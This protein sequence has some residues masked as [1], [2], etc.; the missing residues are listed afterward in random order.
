MFGYD[1]TIQSIVPGYKFDA[2][3]RKHDKERYDDRLTIR[4]N[5]IDAF[6][7]L[8]GFVEKH[9]NDPFYIEGT[10]SISL[11]SLIFRE[12][13]ANIIAHR[14]YTSAA[15]ATMVIYADRV[16]FRNPN[17]P[18][19]H[20]RIDPNNFTPYPKNPTIC[21]FMIQLGRYEEL[22]SGV[23]KVN[24][25]LPHYAPGAGKPLFNDG[26]MFEVM[27]PLSEITTQVTTQV[28]PQVTTQ[29]KTL[30]RVLVGEME[31]QQIMQAVGLKSRKNLRTSYLKPAMEHDLIE[32]VQSN[33]PTSPTQK[34]RLTAK[35]RKLL[36]SL[37]TQLTSPVTS[38]VTGEVAGAVVKRTSA[39]KR[40]F[41]A[42]NGIET[43]KKCGISY[44][45]NGW[46]SGAQS[47]LGEAQARAQSLSIL[48]ALHA[49]GELSAES[50]SQILGLKSKSG[51][52]KR[53][54]QALLNDGKIEFTIPEKPT[55]R[56]QKYRLTRN[57]RFFIKRL[58][59]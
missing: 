15:P 55:S 26:N 16:E 17:V 27:V 19:Y 6:D 56:L 37:T 20:G 24:R 8:M 59:S 28:A 30:L 25:Y 9:L 57:G 2:L 47:S 53:S 7:Q 3:L 21:K 52:F 32:M 46:E 48:I 11:R 50:L 33:S 10:T 41:M 31:G 14:E 22:G 43:L 23:R 12:L 54:L 38:H 5:L 36:S 35:G 1:A 34:Y 39:K 45:K 4:S 29:V 51:A 44:G 18:H 40:E 49:E 42:Y 13:V 58:H